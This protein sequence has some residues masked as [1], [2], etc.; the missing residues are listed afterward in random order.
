MIP[1]VLSIAGSDPSG[2]AGIQADLKT[3]S[4]LG[5]YG[6]AAITALTAQNTKG[7]TGVYELPPDFVVQQVMAVFDDIRVD[8]VKIGMAGSAKTIS[9]LAD[10]LQRKKPGVI[11]LDPVMVA[12]S[13]DTLLSADGVKRLKIDLI[14]LAS[15][16]TPNIPEAEILLGR[17]FDGKFDLFAKDL[18]DL[19]ARAVL[20]KGGHLEGDTARDIY[21]DAKNTQILELKRVKTKNNHGTGCTLS[22]AL[23][24]Y[25]AKGL[26][27][28]EAAEHAK[29]YVNNA[30]IASK[31]L[32]V[33]QGAGPVNHFHSVWK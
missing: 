18:L 11:V 10:L 29:K 15:V 17:K 22:S 3:F 16:I 23:A 6:M 9:F 25:M 31:D 26:P 19:G 1:N 20:L 28:H 12:Q 33:G 24:T 32:K 2:G 13:G 27:G 21:M 14:P 5:A 30:L 7:V 8:A 4:A